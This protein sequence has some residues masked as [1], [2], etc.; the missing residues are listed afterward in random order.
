MFDP[1]YKK[2][3]VLDNPIWSVMIPA[4]NASRYLAETLNSVIMQN[5]SEE[6]MEIVVVDNCSTDNTID[7]VKSVGKGRVQW[8]Q[9]KSNI[10]M[11]NN[12]NQCV[13]LS[14]GKYIH[15][16][17]A[18]D[19]VNEDFYKVM[20]SKLDSHPDVG[21]ISCTAEV[22]NESSQVIYRMEP[23]KQLLA[24]TNNIEELMYDNPL[25]TPA[26]VVRRQSYT[27]LGLFDTNMSFVFDWEMWVR[28]IYKCKGLQINDY[29]C[30]YRDHSSSET[31]R[32][33]NNGE[34]IKNINTL[35]NRFAALGYPI[36][37]GEISKK[38]KLMFEGFVNNTPGLN[39]SVYKALCYD[40]FGL[41]YYLKRFYFSPVLNRV[42]KIF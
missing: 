5:Y 13:K 16:L 40:C 34:Y 18:D 9:N 2:M 19:L 26:V 41:E 14:K 24:P 38:M 37:K 22:I 10:G 30:G 27:N 20:G 36:D 12:F 8:A 29:L 1:T 21:L 11:I 31:S 28:I 42:K 23:S 25:R 6:E 35:M 32:V 4:Y 3:K 15:I 39:K 7:I 33:V 17:N